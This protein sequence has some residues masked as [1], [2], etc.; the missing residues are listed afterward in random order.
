MLFIPPAISGVSSQKQ[1]ISSI[2]N[3]TLSKFK[4]YFSGK[5]PLAYGPGP[6]SKGKNKLTVRQYSSLNN[7][8]DKF[9]EWFCG[10]TDAEGCFRIE[11]IS[12]QTFQFIFKILLHIDDIDMLYYIKDRLGIG[13]VKNYGNT[14]HFVVTSQKHLGKII[15]IFSDYP[16]KSTKLLNFL[17][18]KRAFEL[19][20]SSKNKTKDLS[21]E[22]EK[23]KNIMNRGRL[24]FQ[25]PEGHCPIVTSYWL[26]GF[27]EGEG[28]FHLDRS[29]NRL[30]FNITLSGN[31][32][33]LLEAIKY[34]LYDLPEVES[35]AQAQNLSK[36]S[37]MIYVSKSSTR[38]AHLSI[39]NTDFIKSVIIPFFSSMD[40]HSKKY[41]DFQDWVL[42]FKLK[43]EG[44]HYTDQGLRLIELIISQMN[45]NRLSTSKSVRVDRA[46]LHADIYGMLSGPSNYEIKGDRIYIKSLNKYLSSP[47]AKVVQLVDNESG[48]TL[49]TFTSLTA[50][51][52][53]LGMPQSTVWVKYTK[54]ESVLF[55]D[56]LV[57]IKREVPSSFGATTD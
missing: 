53:S 8:D 18:F 21:L 50:C 7:V 19:Y 34:F 40:W 49:Q 22:I 6:R 30:I 12:G 2:K 26:L 28:S 25:L 56:K 9:Y 24:D 15:N 11:R 52:K 10:I 23:I 31:D 37:I 44:H 39:K 27:V 36:S 5:F 1:T 35:S 29:S 45:N 47:K 51:A 41:L 38:A 16:L 55:N 42:V 46:L 3:I 14:A 57:L 54:G 20:I 17:E 43:E 13:S 4:I 33:A 48:E 32:L